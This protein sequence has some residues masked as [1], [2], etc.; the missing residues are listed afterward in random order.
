VYRVLPGSVAQPGLLFHVGRLKR[1]KGVGT[2]IRALA[3][4]RGQAPEARLVIGGSG[5]DRPYLEKLARDAGVGDAVE[6]RGYLGEAEKV[7][8]YNEAAVFLNASLKEGWGLTSVEAN[9]CGTPVV[10]SDAPGLRDSV[11]HGETGLLAAPD[12]P[13][14]FAAAILSILRDPETAARLR[15]GALAWAA[16]HDWDRAFEATRDVL[17]RAWRPVRA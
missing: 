4:V 12:D 3:L 2:L 16:V 6:F 7:R 15:A 5:D 9:A 1:Y 14:A 11:R 10:A 17:L 13:A 8:L